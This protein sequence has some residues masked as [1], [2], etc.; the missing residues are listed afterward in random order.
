MKLTV[1]NISFGIDL[2]KETYEKA[3]ITQRDID[4]IIAKS[5]IKVEKSGDKTTIVTVVL[6]NGFV[7]V[8]SSSCVDSKN[9]NMKIGKEICMK[10]ITDKI[11]ELEGYKLQS[12]KGDE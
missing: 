9:F 8:E 7:L 4:E 11:W 12:A 5:I 3:T 2:A 1:K 6:S 10:K